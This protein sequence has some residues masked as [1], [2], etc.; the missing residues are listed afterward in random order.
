M[1]P[2]GARQVPLSMGYSRQEYWS[3]LPC[4]PPGNLPHPGTEPESIM[5][6]VLA[7]EFFTTSALGEANEAPRSKFKEAFTLGDGLNLHPEPTSATS[8]PLLYLLAPGSFSFPGHKSRCLCCSPCFLC[9]HVLPQHT[10]ALP[11]FVL[12][13]CSLCSRLFTVPGD[14]PAAVQS[15]CWPLSL[16]PEIQFVFHALSR[17][18]TF[19]LS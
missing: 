3:G 5:S 2:H 6:P 10:N 19:S 9:P 14:P 4:P 16:S 8:V 11:V 18:I 1:R 7:G 12:W 17:V 13:H 15:C